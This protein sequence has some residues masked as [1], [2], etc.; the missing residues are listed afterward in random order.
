MENTT[1]QAIPS[2]CP[3][4]IA[5]TTHGVPRHAPT[6]YDAKLPGGYLERARFLGRRPAQL[7]LMTPMGLEVGAVSSMTPPDQP[8]WLQHS[9]SWV[10]V[11]ASARSSRPRRVWATGPPVLGCALYK[12]TLRPDYSRRTQQRQ[13][14]NANQRRAPWSRRQ[15]RM[16]GAKCPG[17]CTKR[18]RK[19]HNPP[20]Q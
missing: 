8:L 5:G 18:T 15:G 16:N 10:G 17:P 3:S 20:S 9:S 14:S 6:T 13:A 2:H 12:G 19:A 11:L 1:C 7:N 4:Q